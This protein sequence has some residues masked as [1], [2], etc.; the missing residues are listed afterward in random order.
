MDIPYL[1]P[2]V[3]EDFPIYSQLNANDIMLYIMRNRMF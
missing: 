3:M 1:Y 2:D